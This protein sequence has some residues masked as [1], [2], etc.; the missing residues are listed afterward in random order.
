MDYPQNTKIKLGN[1]CCIIYGLMGT[2]CINSCIIS[3]VSVDIANPFYASKN[4]A[5]YSYNNNYDVIKLT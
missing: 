1:A 2:M 4:L 5:Q 3:D